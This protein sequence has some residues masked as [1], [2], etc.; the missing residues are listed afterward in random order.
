MNKSDID[1]GLKDIGKAG[2]KLI[3]DILFKPLILCLIIVI[4]MILAL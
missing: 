2:D 4:L 1:Q 3:H